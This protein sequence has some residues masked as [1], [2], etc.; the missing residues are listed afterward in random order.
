M[1]DAWGE[2]YLSLNAVLDGNSAMSPGGRQQIAEGIY[3]K[4]TELGYLS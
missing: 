1:Q 3:D 4:L 2:H